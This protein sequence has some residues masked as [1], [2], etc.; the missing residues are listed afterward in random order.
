MIRTSRISEAH[1]ELAHDLVT[2]VSWP[3]VDDIRVAI[4][5]HVHVQQLA[6]VVHRGL[7]SIG[8]RFN[9]GE[10]AI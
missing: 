9:L 5:R 4:V 3:S 10:S 1:G 2:H 8:T 7:D 6:V